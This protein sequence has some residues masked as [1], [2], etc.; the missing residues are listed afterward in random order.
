M[1]RPWTEPF[2]FLAFYRLLQV[3]GKLLNQSLGTVPLSRDVITCNAPLRA[4]RHN[5]QVIIMNTFWQEIG[6]NWGN[7]GKV[8][9]LTSTIGGNR[10]MDQLYTTSQVSTAT[11]KTKI[12]HIS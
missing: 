5:L 2:V 10:E 4:T 8:T 9:R 6:E 11:N 1:C 7:L 12:S 3:A